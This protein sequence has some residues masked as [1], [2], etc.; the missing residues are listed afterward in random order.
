[1]KKTKRKWVPF[2]F[3]DRTGIQ[4]YLEKQARQGWLLE[5]IS[6]LGWKFRRVEPKEIRFA[7]TYF[8]KASVFDPEPSEQQLLF[9]DFCAQTGWK[10]A[11]S[12]AQLQVFYNEQEDPVP[13]ETDATIEVANI[14]AA[15]KKDFLPQYGLLLL[16]GLLQM[17]LFGWRLHS[18]FPGELSSNASLFTGLS[19]LLLLA[20]CVAEIAG[21][22][23]WYRR[24]KAAAELDGSFLE[25][26]GHTRMQ[27]VVLVMIFVA[28][29]AMLV[30]YG[31]SEMTAV[32][33]TSIGVMLA[34]TALIVGISE[35]MK[36]WKLSAKVN[37]TVTILMTLVISFGVAGALLIAIVSRI[38]AGWRDQDVA[39]TYEYKG[40]VWNVY[41]DDLPLI[42]EDLIDTDY[43][44]YSYHLQTERESVLA[45]QKVAVQRPR[46]DALEQPQ[47]EYTVTTVKVPLLYGWCKQALLEEFAHNYG[48]P[49]P[50]DDLWKQEKA[51]DPVPWKANE[52]Y[53]LYLGGDAMQRY[54]LCYDTCIV[55]IDF[56]HDWEVTAEQMNTVAEKLVFSPES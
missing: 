54:L 26:R 29:G 31:S 6:A 25:T 55:E 44:A 7:V 8:P 17:V 30:S 28:F 34:L 1:M 16:T 40:M 22:F 37:R 33:L 4:T 53:Q 3:Y 23:R 48:H 9:W 42:I 46:M 15:A 24:A 13:I 5:K 21:Y 38:G 11:A 49:D 51:V 10:L 35:L 2:S 12:S 36:R 50:E 47:L 43:E 20:L 18:D 56:E 32:A 45:G 41:D 52:A 19:W 39:E 27:L 14:H